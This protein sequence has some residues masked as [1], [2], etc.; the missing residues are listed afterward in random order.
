[1]DQSIRQSR[2]AWPGALLVFAAVLLAQIPLALNP[3]YFSHDE[4]QWAAFANGGGGFSWADVGTF[5]YRPLTF[6]LWMWLSRHLFP[7]P[8]AFHLVLACWGAANAVLLHRVLRAFD[9]M[10]RPAFVAAF[11]FAL[12]PFAVYVHGWVG[13]IGDLLWL[14]CALLAAWVALRGQ[15]LAVLAVVVLLLTTGALLAKESAVSIPALALVALLLDQPRRQRWLAATLASLLPVL[16]YLALRIGVLLAPEH[17]GTAYASDLANMPRRWA[18]YQVFP[19][20]VGVMEIFNTFSDGASLRVVLAACLWLALVAALARVGWRWSAAF[21]AGGAAALGPVLVLA[22]SS[23]QYGYAF[24]AVCCGVVAAAWPRMRRPAR[25]LV[26][27]YA[28]LVVWHGANVMRGI[29]EVGEVQAVFSPALARAVA[30]GPA[31]ASAPLRLASA[32]GSKEW[33]FLRLSHEIPSYDGVPIGDRVR[34]VAAGE[35]ADYVIQPDGHL[36]RV[37]QDVPAPSR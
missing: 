20:H 10:P 1:M 24:A 25:A 11:V 9:V 4:L 22:A 26:T 30:D 14:S 17:Q 13:T 36:A 5:Q 23:N 28:L 21:V 7:H 16:A 18:E 2:L 27:L 33:M 3:G 31:S 35:A 37:R 6:N 34:I 32:P 8:V 15:R 12:S 19:P 29:R